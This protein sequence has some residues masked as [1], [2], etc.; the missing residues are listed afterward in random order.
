M[1]SVP[2][3]RVDGY[4]RRPDAKVAGFLLHGTDPGLIREHGETL[5]RQLAAGFDGQPE[6]IRVVDEEQASAAARLA[7][8]IQTQPMFSA[9]KIV[10]VRPS[11][12]VAADLVN[13]AWDRIPPGV[14]VII[15]AGNLKRDHKLR[16]AFETDPKLAA[17]AC[18]DND[19][20]NGDLQFIRR[21]LSEAGARIDSAAERH[22]AALLGGDRGVVK[23]ELAKLITYV[24][25]ESISAEAVEAVI[26]D[27]SRATMDAA[28][29]AILAGDAAGAFRQIDG[30]REAGASFDA[31]LSALGQHVFRLMRLRASMDSG[32]APDAA[33]RAFRPP[34]HF[35]RADQLKRQ[36]RDWKLDDLKRVMDASMDTLRLVRTKP[37][38][39]EA[40]TGQ[41]VL[42][43]AAFKR[44]RNLKSGGHP[45]SHPGRASS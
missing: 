45:R 35:R 6:I 3:S 27:T 37:Q 26:G 22:L 16:R 21:E 40:L 29:D 44:K 2:A 15:E 24:G 31:L 28:V 13:Y 23:S 18:H 17:L 8:E 39:D 32:A 10:L 34:V 11:G 30:L 4:V 20:G 38:L 25:G 43:L 19:G 42:R 7:V 12:R 14:K 36:V 9:A 5:L 1:T 41:I 33:I